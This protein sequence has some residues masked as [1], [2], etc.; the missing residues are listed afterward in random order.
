MST[1]ERAIIT[2]ERLYSIPDRTAHWHHSYYIISGLLSPSLTFTM[3][4]ADPP[5]HAGGEYGDVRARIDE[6]KLNAYLINN[7]PAVTVPVT[8]KQFKVRRLTPHQL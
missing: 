8:V 5:K 2:R 7:V 4:N 3:V 6:D 1:V